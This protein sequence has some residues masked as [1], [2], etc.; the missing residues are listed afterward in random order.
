MSLSNELI[1]Q[2]AKLTNNVKEDKRETTVYGTVVEYNG[3]T[4]VKLDG[5]EL[6][7]PISTTTDTQ[8]G[9]RV[10]VMIKNHTATVT[11]NI[12]SPSARTD[13]V[14]EI[15]NKVSEFEI[16]VADKVSTKQ[17][18][19]QIARIDTL[20]SDNVVIK[21]KLTANEAVINNLDTK[22]AKIENLNSTN[23][24][25][26]SLKAS[27]LDASVAELKYAEIKDL[28]ATNAKINNL[29]SIYATISNLEATNASIKN[30]DSKYA[31]IENLNAANGRIDDLEAKS[32]TADSAVI[33][34]LEAD[35]AKV[36]TLIFGSATGDVIQTSFAN[37]I[38]A[39]LGNA[40]IKS[41]MIDTVSADKIQSGS[42]STNNVT[43]TSSDGKL[44]IADET[45]QIKD[46]N[47]TR[48]QIGKDA[49]G[50]YSINIWDA[51]GNLMFSEGGLTEN[52]IKD[53]IIRDDMVS[54]TANISASK[55]NI[56]SLFKVINEDGSNTLNSSKIAMDAEGQTLDVAFASMTSDVSGLKGT[57]SSQG[58]SISA[59]QG[60]ISSKVW[61]QDINEAKGEMSTQYSNLEQSVNSFKASVSS[62]YATKDEVDD[63]STSAE[64]AQN[65]A[66]SA[67]NRIA[68]AEGTIAVHSDKIA[69]MATKKELEGYS[70]ITETEA[71][72]DVATKA[73]TTQ[74]S[75]TYATKEALSTTDA[76]IQTTADSITSS[77]KSTYATKDEVNNIEI[78]ARNLLLN[79]S[80]EITKNST[81][82][83]PEFVQY[84]DVA[85]IFD[86]YGLDEYTISFDIKSVD[87]SKK[88]TVDVYCQNG[89][90]TK[91]G[92][93]YHTFPVTTEYV[94]HHFTVT[95]TL[96]DAAQTQAMLAFCGTYNT[97]NIPWVKNVKIEKGN[98]AT[99]WTPAPED[100]DESISETAATLRLEAD[101]ISSDVTEVVDRVTVAESS[102]QQLADSL[103]TLITDENG[104]TLM[105]QT[106]EGWTFNMDSVTGPLNSA[107]LNID[108]LT[109]DLGGVDNTVNALQQAVKDLGVLTD[110]V[111][112]TTYNGQPCIEL[113]EAE[114]GFKLRITNTQIQ[115]L[116][117]GIIPAWLSN[118]KLYIEK[119][120]VTNE[121]QF[122]GFV[123]KARANGNMGLVWKGVSS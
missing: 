21:E 80:E 67:H 1:S 84:A 57:V 11:G 65:S 48:V 8:P 5:S 110:Y 78:G 25:I 66:N 56:S 79:S 36:D 59:I 12:S 123:W 97:G 52:A 45:I 24:E 55:L 106:A 7:T 9:E 75:S 30:L 98:K 47:R 119:A 99:D 71:K 82:T 83:Q 111:I 49:S 46:Q 73:I 120:E 101:G 35:V 122:G 43:V 16:I 26:E 54:D 41:A 105:K 15:G 94:R 50:D 89:S 93:G 114:N 108:Q 116:T 109:K 4:Y 2:F 77:V 87:I 63:V 3:S 38:I 34:D 27:K 103:S 112:I 121:L 69:L 100:V 37:A 18:D 29:D 64:N 90:A 31:K 85:P 32:L 95:P 28:E 68:V 62:T 60:Q 10:T 40:Q 113:G 20:T 74:V 61:Q 17:L 19:A 117:D 104:E 102:I 72:I 81:D 58:T 88:A 13:D 115:F 76:K 107:T 44:L 53:S 118:Q 6:L 70:T 14:K 42:I 39:Q 92:I 33:K 51:D 86:E 22:Y 91:Y 96:Q 23:A